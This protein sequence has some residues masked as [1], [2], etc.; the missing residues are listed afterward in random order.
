M[1]YED[2]TMFC[3]SFISFFHCFLDF[4]FMCTL[5][6]RN[7]LIFFK[8][9]STSFLMMIPLPS[10][11]IHSLRTLK[12]SLNSLFLYNLQIHVQMSLISEFEYKTQFLQIVHKMISNS[13]L[14]MLKD[15]Y[16]YVNSVK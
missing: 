2:N 10:T 7:T 5:S 3:T 9:N 15:Y 13:H 1:T 14:P 8:K 11:K 4:L 16:V 6:F 12:L